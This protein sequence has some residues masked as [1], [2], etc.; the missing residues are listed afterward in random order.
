MTRSPFIRL[1]AT[2]LW[3]SCA[4][5]GLGAELV[6]IL[7]VNDLHGRLA[8]DQRGRGGFAYVASVIARERE[9]APAS[10]LLDAGDMV[11]GSPVSTL[12]RGTPVYE[13][14]NSLG[15]DVHALG[16]H[17]FDYG[18][19]QIREFQSVARAPIISA[20]VVNSD[21]DL[22]LP[23]SRVLRVGD[24]DIGVI[25]ALT[26]RLP[27]LIAND[28][29]G[30]WRALPLVPALRPVV[31]AIHERVDLVVV[32]AHLFDDED[33]A[34]LREL[35]DVDVL[36][37]GHN[38]GGWRTPLVIDGRIGVKLRPYGIEVGRLDLWFDAEDSRITEFEWKRIPVRRG[39]VTEHPGTAALVRKWEAKVSEVVDVPIGTCS[40]DLSRAEVQRL[41]ERAIRDATGATLAY[42][43]R[44][45]VRES[46]VRGAISARDIWNILPF[47]NELVEASILGAELPDEVAEGRSIDARTRYRVVTNDFVAGKW[48]RSGTRFRPTGLQLRDTVLEWVRNRGSVP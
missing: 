48:Q 38:H 41:V 2:A 12:F 30:P 33:E 36:V 1:L 37:G 10:I 4:I 23:P 44:G 11:Q 21:G 15:I 35:T 19:E 18:W 9:S 39:A 17:E 25:G 16:N 8:P 40:R 29:A 26:P 47:D 27:H 14:A 28:L 42:M 6:S 3:A 13:V 34:V 46:L 43:N 24:I 5:S 31:S 22:L 20:N 7:H 45:G 32:L